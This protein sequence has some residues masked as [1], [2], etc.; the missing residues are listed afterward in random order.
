MRG[1][2]NIDEVGDNHIEEVPDA[3]V[4][5]LGDNDIGVGGQGANKVVAPGLRPFQ[6]S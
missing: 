2:K 3:R 5:D 1:R 4:D 6:K